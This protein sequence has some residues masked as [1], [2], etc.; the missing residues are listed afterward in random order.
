MYLWVFHLPV[1]QIFYTDEKNKLVFFGAL[2]NFLQTR[3][4][5]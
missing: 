2:S 3:S 1:F 4:E 5:T